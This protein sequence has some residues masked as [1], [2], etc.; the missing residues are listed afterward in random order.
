MKFS[1]YQNSRQGPRANNQDRMAYSY[2]K[3]A[4]LA[5]MADGM[6][7]HLHG[8]I[9]AQLAV[10]VLTDAFQRLALPI[11]ANPFRFLEEHILQLHAEIHHLTHLKNFPESPRTTLV[12]ALIQHDE[13]Y[14]V[15]VGDSRLYHIR[16]GRVI[17]R[18]EDHSKVQMLFKNGL[19]RREELLTHPERN[20]IYNCV[21]GESPPQID[22][23]VKRPM[24]EG[25]TIVLCTDGVWSE[26]DDEDMLLQL[27]RGTVTETTPGLLDL[28]EKRAGS[29]GDNMSIIA[30][31]WGGPPVQ[32]QVSTATLPL[33]F[34]TT[35][36][37]PALE[38]SQTKSEVQDVPMLTD[39]EIEKAIA[40][41]QASIRKSPR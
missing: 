30:L 41:I 17:F 22:K 2:S 40:E 23:A 15:H 35:F 12:A 34:T 32:Q 5:V 25:D 39:E 3:N 21:G 18:T 13:L 36:M 37:E 26:I 1:I 38:S 6:G 7:G 11:L 8:E 10:K 28:A 16:E 4:L 29:S 31:N 27:G 33:S 24:L 20:M 19:I 14:C 9:A